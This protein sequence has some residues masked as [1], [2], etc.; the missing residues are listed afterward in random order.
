MSEISADVAEITVEGDVL[1]ITVK[2]TPKEAIRIKKL[3]MGT[4]KPLKG[5]EFDLYQIGQIENGKPK[6]GEIPI[7]GTTGDGGILY[8]DGLEMDENISYYLFETK[9]LN[10][11]NRLTG[12]VVISMNGDKVTAMLNGTTLVTQKL[13]ETVGGRKIDVWEI[14]VY[15]S[16]GYVL[17]R[18]GGIGTTLFYVAGGMMVLCAGTVLISRRRRRSEEEKE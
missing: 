3:E 9:A 13:E 8:L 2:N 5:V 16:T 14:T 4:K 15:N 6:A 12:P 17:P 7:K 11:Y 1:Q 10:G 18:T